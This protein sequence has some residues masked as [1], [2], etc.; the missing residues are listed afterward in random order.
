MAIDIEIDSSGLVK[1]SAY[2]PAHSILVQQ[3]GTGSPTALQVGNNTLVGR[4]SGGG[5]AINDL[6]ATD[7]KTMLDIQISD[8]E[9]LQTSLDGKQPTGDY[10]TN[11]ALSSGLA[12]K[13]PL[14]A[15]LMPYDYWYETRFQN[16]NNTQAHLAGF[17]ISGGT[18]SAAVP[19]LASNTLYPYGIFLRSATSVN[20][21]FKFNTTL[22]NSDF[23]GG[24]AKKFQT[25]IMW[26]TSF[27]GRTVR[28]GYHD[29]GTN[30]DATDGAYFEVLDNVVNCKT[31]TNSVR[32]TVTMVSTLSIDEIYL[33]DIESN[34]DG[35]L[36]TYKLI[37]ANTNVVIETATIDTN[38]PTSS[39]R[40]FAVSL[41]AT[42]ATT[43]SSDICVIYYVGNGTV[44]GFNRQRN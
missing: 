32:T 8:V 21:G 25:A 28:V 26:K 29:S 44:N 31:S 27:T 43:T 14:I 35:T 5:S 4:L 10:A 20:G 37:N 33:F 34:T 1:K 24:V 12:T 38:I 39:T 11:T 15:P 36:I 13:Q 41:V 9:N 18:S 7:V 40:G 17:A 3:S 23:F 22:I 19:I 42:E 16:T 30:A 6:S 2:T